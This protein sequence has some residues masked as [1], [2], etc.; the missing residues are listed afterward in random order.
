MY[1]DTIT[2]FNKY[3]SR[4]GDMWYPTVIC[5]VNLNIDRAAIM[6][7]YGAESKDA[8]VLNVGYEILNGSKYVDGKLYLPP[9]EWENQT[10]NKLSD[11][12]TFSSGNNADFF[13]VGDYGSADP[14][15]DDDYD[16]GFYNYMNKSKD[17]VFV[18]TSV[19]EYSAIPHFEIL[20]A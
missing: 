20:G 16:D 5:G 2:L 13:I 3:E 9:K 18:I 6:A 4:L 14:I 11:S 19:G 8:V 17:N 10:N 15:P 1:L 7:K 12:L